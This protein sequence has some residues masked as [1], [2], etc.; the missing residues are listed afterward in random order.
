[1]PYELAITFGRKRVF[2][3][4][5]AWQGS[6]EWSR[7]EAAVDCRK[8]LPELSM[9]EADLRKYETRSSA[10]DTCIHRRILHSCSSRRLSV[11]ESHRVVRGVNRS[12]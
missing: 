5:S 8:A 1:M 3:K 4:V 10:A 11:C 6:A 2:V 7:Y 12:A 9:L